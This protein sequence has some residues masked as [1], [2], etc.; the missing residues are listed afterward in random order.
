MLPSINEWLYKLNKEL[1]K[2]FKSNELTKKYIFEYDMYSDIFYNGNTKDYSLLLYNTD[3]FDYN[4]LT[5]IEKINFT[6]KL[7]KQIKL[8]TYDVLALLNVYKHFEENAFA[9]KFIQ[10]LDN[11][12]YVYQIYFNKNHIWLENYYKLLKKI[13]NK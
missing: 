10:E 2:P 4:K 8:L 11:K 12:L 1:Y 9:K 13:N 6:K 3:K 5:K 7:N